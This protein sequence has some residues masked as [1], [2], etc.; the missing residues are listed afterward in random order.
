MTELLAVSLHDL[1]GVTVGKSSSGEG[2]RSKATIMESIADTVL[3]QGFL[4][5]WF[6]INHVDVNASS[7]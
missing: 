7:L 4:Q 6:S 1:Q 3:R 2:H 5:R